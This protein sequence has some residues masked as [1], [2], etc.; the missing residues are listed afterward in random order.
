MIS[1]LREVVEYA[2]AGSL[3][4]LLLSRAQ[5]SQ[6][7]V[8]PGGCIPGVAAHEA[9]KVVYRLRPATCPGSAYST[10]ATQGVGREGIE[11]AVLPQGAGQVQRCQPRLTGPVVSLGD[12]S[13]PG[14]L[15]GAEPDQLA[16]VECDGEVVARFILAHHLVPV[17]ARVRASQGLLPGRILRMG[18]R[19]QPDD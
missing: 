12:Q 4:S 16:E 11:A 3:G 10:L 19:D 9:G 6:Q 2:D 7:Q 18:G 17:P 1:E 8:V 14:F 5:L 13:V 15:Q